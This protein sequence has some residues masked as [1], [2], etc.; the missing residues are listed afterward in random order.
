MHLRTSTSI[1][2]WCLLSAARALFMGSATPAVIA[3]N[4]C[5]K[6]R[7]EGESVSSDMVELLIERALAE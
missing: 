1:A 3:G 6:A 2:Q 4:A 5:R 7:R